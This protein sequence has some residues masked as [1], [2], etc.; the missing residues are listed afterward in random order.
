[1]LRG[2]TLTL[3]LLV[4]A[5]PAGATTYNGRADVGPAIAG[6]SVVSGQQYSDDSGALKVGG[7]VVARFPA[8][9]G[10]GNQ[11]FFGSV[12]GSPTRLA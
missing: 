12:G 4:L 10:K 8:P 9:T 1:V 5:P 7:R 3:T 6:D 11:R 2:L